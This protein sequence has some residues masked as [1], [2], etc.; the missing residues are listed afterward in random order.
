MFVHSPSSPR[1]SDTHRLSLRRA[2]LRVNT[3]DHK[4]CIPLIITLLA[5]PGRRQPASSR[6]SGAGQMR[7]RPARLSG[8]GTPQTPPRSSGIR[9]A[10]GFGDPGAGAPRGACR[11]RRAGR[12]AA[13]GKPGAGSAGY[14]LSRHAEG[15]GENPIWHA[16][17]GFPLYLPPRKCPRGP[18]AGTTLF[19]H[20]TM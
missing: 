17:K 11:R 10:Q 4:Y 8:L 9:G 13:A 6:A 3:S 14:L 19:S 5:G 20:R 7:T 15:R 12:G 2:C 1:L 16:G 18:G